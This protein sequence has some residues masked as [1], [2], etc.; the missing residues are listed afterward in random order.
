MN[1]DESLWAFLAAVPLIESASLSW[2]ASTLPSAL[3]ICIEELIRIYENSFFESLWQIGVGDGRIRM[4][5]SGERDYTEKASQAVREL[6]GYFVIESARVDLESSALMT[7][8][9]DQLD[10]DGVFV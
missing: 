3:P 4:I 5:E 10:P 2:R 8:I 9:K 1:D 6:G 7:R